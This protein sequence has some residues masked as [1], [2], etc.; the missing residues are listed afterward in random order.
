MGRLLLFLGGATVYV[1]TTAFAYSYFSSQKSALN[2][3]ALPSEQFNTLHVYDK[4]ADAYDS[5]IH[6][7]ERWMG[8][9]LLR[10]WLLAKAHVRTQT[11]SASEF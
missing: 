8:L 10:R 6:S 9:L 11:H 4:V 3:P 5:S 1:S 2:S 7:S